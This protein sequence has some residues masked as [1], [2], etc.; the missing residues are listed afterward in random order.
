MGYKLSLFWY[1]VAL[2]L[3]SIECKELIGHP[4]DRGKDNSNSM[5][6]S[7]QPGE[8]DVGKHQT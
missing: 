2:V 8:T 7:F 3:R 4:K 6:N 1:Q 5:T